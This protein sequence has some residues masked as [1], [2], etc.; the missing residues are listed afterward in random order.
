MSARLTTL[1]WADLDASARDAALAR[2]AVTGN[3][4]ID[5]LVADI[6]ALVRDRGD[7][8]LRDLTAKFDGIDIDGLAR[9]RRRD[10]G[11]RG[12]CGRRGP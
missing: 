8:A 12:R 7:D 11:C 3:P 4:D 1:V 6:I 2:P 10:R 5:R 9:R